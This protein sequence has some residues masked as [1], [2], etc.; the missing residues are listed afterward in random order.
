MLPPCV[1]LG[2]IRLSQP[3]LFLLCHHALHEEVTEHFS[4]Y[5]LGTDGGNLTIYI[6]FA[7]T[8]LSDLPLYVADLQFMWQIYI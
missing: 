5:T 4:V 1:N 8:R 7:S 6:W 3:E 2:E